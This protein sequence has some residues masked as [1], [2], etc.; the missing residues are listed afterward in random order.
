M[1]VVLVVVVVAVWG[2]GLVDPS[3]VPQAIANPVL[4]LHCA[5]SGRWG[6]RGMTRQLRLYRELR[7]ELKVS[8]RQRRRLRLVLVGVYF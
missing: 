1:V 7:R 4:A 3:K 2:R 6:A 8:W 5:V